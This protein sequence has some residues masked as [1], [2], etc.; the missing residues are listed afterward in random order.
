M[1]T[2]SDFISQ[3]VSI[4]RNG[5]LHFG[6]S[7]NW[8]TVSIIAKCILCVFLEVLFSFL[9]DLLSCFRCLV[10]SFSYVSGVFMFYSHVFL[11]IFI[12][13]FISVV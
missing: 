12:F 4:I 8:I 11:S 7:Y 13:D 5:V 6:T 1:Y 2:G 3:F 10:V 9:S